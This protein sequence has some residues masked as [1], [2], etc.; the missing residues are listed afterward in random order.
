MDVLKHVAW[1][2]LINDRSFPQ[3]AI[4]L[5]TEMGAML[6]IFVCSAACNELCQV[7][8]RAV[9]WRRQFLVVLCQQGNQVGL[10]SVGKTANKRQKKIY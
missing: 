7:S 2:L 6:F 9:N 4:D 10:L 3:G 1:S 8:G 5:R